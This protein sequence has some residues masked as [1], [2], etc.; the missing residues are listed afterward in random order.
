M[1]SKPDKESGG[2]KGIS[3]R[4]KRTVKPKISAPKV[5][6][7]PLPPGVKDPNET[8]KR[9]PGMAPA[10]GSNESGGLPSG[11][12]P[13]PRPQLND[14]TAD[15]VKRRYSTR[16]ANA[17]QDYTA[18]APPVPS[19]P[20]MPEEYAVKA[21]GRGEREGA[22]IGAGGRK[23]VVDM[24]ELADPKLQPEALVTNLL[25]DASEEEIYSY[26]QKLREAKNRTSTDLQHNVFQNRN[27]FIKISKEAEKLKGEMRT[28]RNLMS[29]LTGA[30]GQ[31]TAAG[32]G[33]TADTAKARRIANRSSVA[34]L[35]AL[36]NTHLQTL[37]KRVEGSQ[38]YL[39]AIPGR[40]IVYESSRW[41]ELNAATWKPRRRVHLILLNDHL[42]VATEKKRTD[43]A[44]ANT[45]DAN[46]KQGPPQLVATRCW[47]LQDVQMAD[48]ATRSTPGSGDKANSSNAINVRVGTDSF[49]FATGSTEAAEK[50]TLLTT[51]RRTV[52]DLRKTLEAESQER[53]KNQD[54]VNYLATSRVRGPTTI[55]SHNTETTVLPRTDILIDIDGKTQ[56][57][58]S[59]ESQIDD[60]DIDIALQRF[61]EAVVR[62]EKLKRIAKGIKGKSIAQNVILRK[63]NE[64]SGKLAGVI[65]RY[66]KETHAWKGST[67][68]NVDW[69]V[70]LGFEDRA[71]EAYL[72]ARGA[73]IKKRIRQVI[74]D[75]DLHTYLYQISFIS[76]TIIRDTALIY[77]S[78][79]PMVM[80]SACVKWAKEHV[81]EFNG[82]LE[83]QLSSVKEGSEVWNRCVRVSKE[84]AG[85][86]GE[87]GLDFRGLVGVGLGSGGG[88]GGGEKRT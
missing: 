30:L 70:R 51:F 38:K 43:N 81:D 42:L 69:L 39:P 79:F 17:P 3:L 23:L 76:F 11:P 18:G 60:L 28:L 37:W 4:K 47:P 50:L 83:R 68:R 87:A 22:G 49:T 59:V 74:F 48:L 15:L 31:A 58:R 29:E 54:S 10:V 82:I 33:P 25:A 44:A 52:E 35:E 64:R 75:G 78:C 27:Q 85:V 26:G 63:L 13:R 53:E 55:D 6:S 71:R 77:Q 8:L 72:E 80:M 1:S 61:E 73:V 12:Q 34:N 46:D 21:L 24:K 20:N 14:K 86:L 16:F 32:G 67:Q 88:G 66:L 9:R 65:V 45:R 57:L 84:H 2:G 56:S 41:V 5:I 19:L 36:W 62:V 40:H 7:G